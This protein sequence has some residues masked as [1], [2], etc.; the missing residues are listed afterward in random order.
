MEFYEK[1]ISPP[2]CIEF[3]ELLLQCNCKAL[4]SSVCGAGDWVTYFE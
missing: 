1:D 3:V 2:H 4:E